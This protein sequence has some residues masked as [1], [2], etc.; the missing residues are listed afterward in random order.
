MVLSFFWDGVKLGILEKVKSKIN[1]RALFRLARNKDEIGT[2]GA[3]AIN[4]QGNIGVATST[5]GTSGKMNGRIGDTPIVGAGTFADDLICGISA[6]GYGEGFIRY[7]VASN[8]AMEIQNGIFGTIKT[9][10]HFGMH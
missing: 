5:G 10:V 4:A 2:V 3:V 8:I 9:S 1:C 7:R 6:T